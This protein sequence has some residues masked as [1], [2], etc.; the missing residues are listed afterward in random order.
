VSPLCKVRDAVRRFV[1][2]DD[3]RFGSKVAI[4]PRPTIDGMEPKGDVDLKVLSAI[5]IQRST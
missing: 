5:E 4:I 1:S 2:T 3:F